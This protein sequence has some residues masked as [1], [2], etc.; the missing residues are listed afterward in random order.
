MWCVKQAECCMDAQGSSA[1]F[2][3]LGVLAMHGQGLPRN[4]T[5]AQMAFERG[6]ALG[7]MDCIFNLGMLYTGTGPILLG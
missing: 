3:G 7:D 4:Y 2:N 5:L 6:A 1:A